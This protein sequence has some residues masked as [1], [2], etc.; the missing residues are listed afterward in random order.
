MDKIDSVEV[1]MTYF[2]LVMIILNHVNAKVE[3]TT[4]YKGDVYLDVS[5][6][7]ISVRVVKHSTTKLT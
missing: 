2:E 5:D 6:E 3:G 1:N 4:F 7:T